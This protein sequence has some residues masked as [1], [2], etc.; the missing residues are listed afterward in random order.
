VFRSGFR[1][2]F[3]LLVRRLARSAVAILALSMASAGAQAQSTGLVASYGF[4]EGT[5]TTVGDSSGNNNTGTISNATWTTSG[6]YGKSLSF[7]GTNSIVSIPDAASLRLTSAMTLEAW[8]YP[9]AATGIWRTVILK[10]FTGDLSYA[11]Y[12][13][14]DINVPAAYLRVG[15]ATRRV[16]GT[17]KVPLNAWT[18]LAATYSSGALRIYVNG[19]MVSTQT[20]TGSIASS[21]LPLR[22]GGNTIWGEY[23]AGRIDEDGRRQQDQ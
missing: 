5:G 16:G 1:V 10:E 18:H 9:T 14:E 8:V 20:G 19:A 7:N 21:T 3:A 11:L 12:A 17:S 2:H 6:K 4:E 15:S 13:D 23:F 22:I